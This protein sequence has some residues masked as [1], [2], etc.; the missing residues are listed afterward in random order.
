MRRTGRQSRGAVTPESKERSRAANL[1]HGIYSA[2]RDTAL[3]ALGEDPA[4]RAARRQEHLEAE[5]LERVEADRREKTLAW[6]YRYVAMV[7]GLS[8]LERFA[9]RPDFYVPPE[10]L[11]RFARD[12][13]TEMQGGTKT[14]LEMLHRLGQPENWEE[15][16]GP[17]PPEV[18]SDGESASVIARSARSAA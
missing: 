7:D 10:Y 5:H 9:R 18:A 2:Q 11:R 12:F 8:Y 3:R 16:V 4:E 1:R 17:Q 6:R 14:L 13:A 15:A